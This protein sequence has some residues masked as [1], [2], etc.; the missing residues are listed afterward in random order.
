MRWCAKTHNPKNNTS[1]TI[2]DFCSL[3][4]SPTIHSYF[5]FQNDCW[6]DLLKRRF[7]L[8]NYFHCAVSP[9]S[10]KFIAFSSPEW[11][12]E[13]SFIVFCQENWHRR[14][15]STISRKNK[16]RHVFIFFFTT[17]VNIT[18][19]FELRIIFVILSGF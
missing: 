15:T 12:P 16:N 17:K 6:T 2:F 14:Q 18:T 19:T 1:S 9:N 11:I 3:C 4:R 5:V 8:D 7:W 13:S 10:K